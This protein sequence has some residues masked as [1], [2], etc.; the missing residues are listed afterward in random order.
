MDYITNTGWMRSRHERV[1]FLR[2][3]AIP[4]PQEL[5]TLC[6]GVQDDSNGIL[7]FHRSARVI[8][9]FFIMAFS[10][11]LGTPSRVAVALITPPVSR[12]TRRM[13]SRSTSSS[14]DRRSFPPRRRAVLPTERAGWTPATG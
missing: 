5:R 14:V 8:P 6:R 7:S 3:T 9:S 11:V 1:Q 12:K 13:Y 10:V 4:A 2:T